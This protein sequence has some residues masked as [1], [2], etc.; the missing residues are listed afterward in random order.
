ELRDR[1]GKEQGMFWLRLEATDR[2]DLSRLIAAQTDADAD[3][4]VVMPDRVN[5]LLYLGG[6]T[7]YVALELTWFHT[8]DVG[9]DYG[10]TERVARATSR[11]GAIDEA[12]RRLTE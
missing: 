8:G 3:E 5:I 7:P 12:A 1:L 11:G 10:F 9:T 2:L 4:V 6:D